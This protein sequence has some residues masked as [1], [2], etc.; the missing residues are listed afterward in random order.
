MASALLLG[1]SWMIQLHAQTTDA[2]T[3][4][5]N[6]AVNKRDKDP[7]AVTADQQKMNPADREITAKI[8]ADRFGPVGRVWETE[9][10]NAIL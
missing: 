2:K 8:I 1:T 10:L 6:S 7:D 4:A 9:C 3:K 5:D